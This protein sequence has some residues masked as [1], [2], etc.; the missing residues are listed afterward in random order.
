M[1]YSEAIK[2]DIHARRVDRLSKIKR[3]SEEIARLQADIDRLEAIRTKLE[4]ENEDIK[5]VPSPEER[6]MEIK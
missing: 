2:R 4:R 3:L 6:M 5:S 1:A